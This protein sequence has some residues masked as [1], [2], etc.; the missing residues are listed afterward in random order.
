MAQK[1]A[2][3]RRGDCRK[4]AV[5]CRKT[6]VDCRKTAVD[7]QKTAVD[8]SNVLSKTAV[9]RFQVGGRLRS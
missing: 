9:C 1:L 7:C 3:T 6:A 2:A 4:T 5:D 8:C